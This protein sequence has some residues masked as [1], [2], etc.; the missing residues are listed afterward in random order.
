MKSVDVL[1]V[2]QGLAGSALAWCLAE[3]G[4]SLLVLDRGGVD[5]QGRPSA[6]RVAAGL[7]T[8]ITGKRLTLAPEW[9][10]MRQ[11]AEAFYRRVE[12][13]TGTAVFH[14]RPAL[15][16]FAS[17]DERGVFQQR[18]RDP[19]Y[20][21]QVRPLLA[22]ELPPEIDA[23]HGGFWMTHAARLDS[24]RFVNAIRDWLVGRD[25]YR[26]A[27]V[28]P[29][30]DL[31][32]EASGVAAPRF[33]VRARVVVYCQGF[34]AMLTPASLREAIIPAHGDVLRVATS[35]P[36]FVTH[37]GVWLAPTF[38]APAD[39]HCIGS[40]YNHDRVDAQPDVGARRQLLDQLQGW[41]RSPIEVLEHTAAIRPTTS[42]RKPIA[43]IENEETSLAVFNGLGAKGA[44]WAPSHAARLAAKLL[45]QKP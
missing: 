28:V 37:Y 6:S 7:M 3:R 13:V 19:S 38:A 36:S 21:E 33:G 5:D 15:R 20:A 22:N 30:E 4:A 44:L 10:A 23:E 40:T 31:I 42:D 41:F 2:G 17:P 26:Q 24:L 18:C 16:L 12:Q 32:L 8:P 1:I 45:D 25:A 14:A 27:E 43:R 39:Q 35:A 29:V 9:N 11:T 34:S